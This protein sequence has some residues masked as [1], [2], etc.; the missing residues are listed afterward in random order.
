MFIFLPVCLSRQKLNS[1][2]A[3]PN[4]KIPA[5]KAGKIRRFSL[6]SATYSALNCS[7]TSDTGAVEYC[8][9][10]HTCRE[11]STLFHDFTPRRKE[12]LQPD[13]AQGIFNAIVH[14]IHTN[15]SQKGLK[16]PFLSIYIMSHNVCYVK[17]NILI[18]KVVDFTT[19]CNTISYKPVNNNC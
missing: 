5:P 11:I 15:S 12:H 2:I 14:S 18:N 6:G 4:A 13:S 9:I 16:P 19:Y 7:V 8:S 17:L 3:I 10:S 1:S